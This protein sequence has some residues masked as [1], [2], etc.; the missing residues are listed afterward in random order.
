VVAIDVLDVG[1]GDAILIG[2]PEGKTA[3]VDAGLDGL[4]REIRRG[5]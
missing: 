2:S 5:R 3:P 1:Q 4:F